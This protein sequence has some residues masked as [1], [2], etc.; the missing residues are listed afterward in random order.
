M[1]L[2]KNILLVFTILFFVIGCSVKDM[3]ESAAELKSE[4]P[5]EEMAETMTAL[6]EEYRA[7]SV[8][9]LMENLETATAAEASKYAAQVLMEKYGL[10]SEEWEAFYEE[11]SAEG[12]FEKGENYTYDYSTDKALTENTVTEEARQASINRYGIGI[13]YYNQGNYN[14]AKDEWMAAVE[15]D[16]NNSDAA[17]GLKRIAFIEQNKE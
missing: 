7:V 6:A 5:P 1:K 11:A 8:L 12:L 13:S 17:L 9:Y 15:L 3:P 10:T 2:S 16:P 4:I 14:K